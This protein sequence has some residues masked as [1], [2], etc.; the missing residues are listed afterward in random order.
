M[1]LQTIEALWAGAFVSSGH[2]ERRRIQQIDEAAYTEAGSVDDKNTGVLPAAAPNLGEDVQ[3]DERQVYPFVRNLL[4]VA[5]ELVQT[6]AN[7]NDQLR[8]WAG[9]RHCACPL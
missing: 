5:G 9:L 6:E 1:I 3:W 4:K 2:G 7:L 8:E